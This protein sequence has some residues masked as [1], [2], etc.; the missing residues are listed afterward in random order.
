MYVMTLSNDKVQVD[1]T[2]TATEKDQSRPQVYNGYYIVEKENGIW[3]LDPHF[4]D[5]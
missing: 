2:D 1:V 4:F 5:R 3:K